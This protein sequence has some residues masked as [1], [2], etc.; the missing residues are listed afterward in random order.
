[1]PALARSAMLAPPDDK[2]HC[3]SARC[4]CTEPTM[5]AVLPMLSRSVMLAAPLTNSCCTLAGKEQGESGC[6]EQHRRNG[7]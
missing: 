2:S 7:G 5:S 1:M 6:G 3:T 4:P